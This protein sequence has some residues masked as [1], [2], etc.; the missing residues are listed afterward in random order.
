M[1]RNPFCQISVFLSWEPRASAFIKIQVFQFGTGSLFKTLKYFLAMIE[2]ISDKEIKK[3]NEELIELHK[4]VILNYLIQKDLSNRT[5]KKFFILYDH[6]IKPNNIRQYFHLPL[7]IFIYC[8]ITD[9]LK[10]V[11]SFRR[12][13]KSRLKKLKGIK[14]KTF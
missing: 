8:L 4:R 5:R 7:K 13:S 2:L 9:R 3:S 1:L 11:T 12:F 14:T 6:Y 10:N